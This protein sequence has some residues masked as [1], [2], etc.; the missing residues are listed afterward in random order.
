MVGTRA[1]QE[2]AKREKREKMEAKLV[3]YKALENAE[4]KKTSAKQAKPPPPP[5]PPA[6]D[7]TVP[8]PTSSEGPDFTPPKNISSSAIAAARQQEY[9]AT[10]RGYLNTDGEKCYRNALVV[11]LLSS[12]RLMSWIENRYIPM[13]RAAGVTIKTNVGEVL[14]KLDH[15]DKPASRKSRKKDDTIYTD[16]W[17]ELK[18]LHSLNVRPTDQ[19]EKRD[20]NS[21]MD[22]FWKWLRE[23]SDQEEDGVWEG[24]FRGFQDC[25]ELLFWWLKLN[26]RLLGEHIEYL[27]SDQTDRRMTAARRKLLET[28][29]DEITT[30]IMT[31]SNTVRKVCV[32]CGDSRGVETRLEKTTSEPYLSIHL[33]YKAGKEQQKPRDM[34]QLIEDDLKRMTR[35][36]RCPNCYEKLEDMKRQALDA[37]K[38]FGKEA[39]EKARRKIAPKFD[40]K[41][42][43]HER[44]RLYTL[45]EVLIV[46]LLRFSRVTNKEGEEFTTKNHEKVKFAEVLDLDPYMEKRI[47]KRSSTKYRLMGVIFHSGKSIEKDGHFFTF[48]RTGLDWYEVSDTRVDNSSFSFIDN[49][50]YLRTCSPYMF[51]Y[52]RIKDDDDNSKSYAGIQKDDAAIRAKEKTAKEKAEVEKAAAK[53]KAERD[54]VATRKAAEKTAAP[55]RAPQK[56]AVQKGAAKPAAKNDASR[57]GVT[58]NGVTGKEVVK[59]VSPEKTTTKKSTVGKSPPRR[60]SPRGAASKK[61]TPEKSPSRGVS[62]RL[63]TPEKATDGKDA[64]DADA[65]HKEADTE[66]ADVEDG[67]PEE[68]NDDDDDDDDDVEDGNPE[69]ANDNDDDAESSNAGDTPSEV[70]SIKSDENFP[71]GDLPTIRAPGQKRTQYL[72][73]ANFKGGPRP[74]QW[75]INVKASIN[76]YAIKW[77][78]YRFKP[79]FSM[80]RMSGYNADLQMDV[81]D[82][83]GRSVK[84][85]GDAEV[86]LVQPSTTRKRKSDDIDADTSPTDNNDDDWMNKTINGGE[87]DYETT[88]EGSSENSLFNSPQ[89]DGPRRSKR[90]K[91]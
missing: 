74:D 34:Q 78:T 80:Q 48:V 85:A 21:A 28:G 90:K 52:D 75:A 91:N 29:V 69:E 71:M 27:L 70:S 37:A 86:K 65:Q 44:L 9:R 26:A 46:H 12:G 58:G 41:K 83:E 59:A 14:E 77:P 42:E 38:A 32:E 87:K 25:H 3:A 81:T 53:D 22:K 66:N 51:I 40:S 18:D 56:A 7:D 60:V 33:D 1:Q 6:Q 82:G 88:P 8:S 68:A 13:L 63:A 11:F 67:N 73:I 23:Q 64:A 36:Y 50:P 30:E 61:N 55:K 45:P 31:I 16:V 19:V 84:V 76:G 15:P 47:P 62:P 57:K 24:K 54:N 20:K 5:A 17:C 4:G 43:A 89:P 39:V 79:W 35:G 49:P 10:P 2:K 72:Q